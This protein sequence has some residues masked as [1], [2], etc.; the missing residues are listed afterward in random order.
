MRFLLDVCVS[1]R[2]L[3]AFLVDQGHDVL[4]AVAIDPRASDERLLA[5]ALEDQRVLVTEDKD[6]GELV[7]VRRLLHGPIVRLVELTVDEQINGMA[8][9][10][11]HH[12]GELTG[13]VLVTLTHS[14]IRIRR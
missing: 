12:A 3:D 9:L 8:E 6:F 5:L 14:R 4:S 7:F 10:L 1:S 13:A 2:S 11:E